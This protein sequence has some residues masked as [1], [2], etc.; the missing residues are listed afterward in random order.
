MF[1]VGVVKNKMAVGLRVWCAKR[2]D[3][4]KKKRVENMAEE[5]RK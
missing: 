3:E 4:V 1:F 5:T 2:K